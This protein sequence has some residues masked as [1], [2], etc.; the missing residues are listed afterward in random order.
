MGYTYD[1]AGRIL[2]MTNWTGFPSTS[3]RVTTWNYNAYRGWL[4]SKTYDGGAARP[5]Y[6]YTS[7][8][9]LR[10]RTWVLRI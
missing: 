6:G 2:T 7:A 4:D 8:E 9:R 10:T 5:S 1:Y 3:A